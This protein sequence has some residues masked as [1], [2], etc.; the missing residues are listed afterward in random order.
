MQSLKTSAPTEVALRPMVRLTFRHTGKTRGAEYQINLKGV[1]VGRIVRLAGRSPDLYYAYSLGVAVRFNT[2]GK[3]GMTLDEAKRFALSQF[4]KRE[5]QQPH[6]ADS[7]AARTGS[8]FTPG[9]WGIELDGTCSGIWPHIMQHGDDPSV[10]DSIAELNTTHSIKK[11][12]MRA[13]ATFR[14]RPDYF[15]KTEGHDKTMANARLIAAAPE[16]LEA[17]KTIAA[18]A[19][20]DAGPF[21]LSAAKTA[22]AAIAKALGQNQLYETKRR[23]HTGS[24]G[25]GGG[26]RDR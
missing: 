2:A 12:H 6:D 23:K 18:F 7:S 10:D 20:E 24:R 15:Q 11:R 21:A 4:S 22:R 5:T 13:V 9:P 3:C 19:E 16:L 8:G 25:G 1:E 26:G 14:E 17:L